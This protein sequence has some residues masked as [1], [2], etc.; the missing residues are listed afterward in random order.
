MF[1]ASFMYEFSSTLYTYSAKFSSSNYK[2]S[3]TVKSKA[4]IKK[5]LPTKIAVKNQ[6][7]YMNDAKVFTMKVLTK[8]GKNVKDGKLKINGV[9]TVEVKNGKAKVVKYGLG[10]KHLKRISGR[11][12][13]YKKHES[14]TFK[15]KYVTLSH[16][17][18]PSTK[19]VKITSVFKCPGCGKTSTHNH[20]AV[21]YY[22]SIRPASLY[23]RGFKSSLINYKY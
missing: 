3:K 8:S 13:Y 7:I 15:V 6:K 20:Y 2:K 16:K 17:Y 23:I 9:G 11:S 1:Y 5:R 14:K 22:V 10:I 19:K 12:E 21:G 4:T 18:L